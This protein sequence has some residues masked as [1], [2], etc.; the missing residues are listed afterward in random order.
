MD[1][2]N[3]RRDWLRDNRETAMRF[4]RAI[5]I[6]Y[7]VVQKDPMVVVHVYVQ[8]GGIKEAWV[9]EMYQDV[10]PPNIY[11]WTDH[12]YRYSLVEDSGFHRRLAYL[13][14]FRLD[15]KIITQEANVHNALD[16]SVITEVLKTW[17]TGQ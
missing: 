12:G 4:L 16:V 3:V 2:Y 14:T 8:E 13:A 10:P 1:G 6:A 5:L 9:K 11:W 15:E 17:K 7:D